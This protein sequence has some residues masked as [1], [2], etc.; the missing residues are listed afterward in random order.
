MQFVK[1]QVITSRSYRSGQT[2]QGPVFP[3]A[4]KST[5][6]FTLV[7]TTVTQVEVLMPMEEHVLA[8]HAVPALELW[9]ALHWVCHFGVCLTV[10][11][12]VGCLCRDLWEEV[13]DQRGR[14]SFCRTKI[15][16][17]S[18]HLCPSLT[19]KSLRL[20]QFPYGF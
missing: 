9:Q 6:A 15:S 1:L 10:A 13:C 7:S 5:A 8:K 2:S 18:R 19:G 17:S 3:V 14:L 11:A 12:L 16:A 4:I 20:L